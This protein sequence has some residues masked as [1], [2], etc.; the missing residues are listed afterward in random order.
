MIRRFPVLAALAIILAAGACAN[1]NAVPLG[2]AFGDAVESNTSRHVI[3]PEPA[4][5]DAGAPPLDG[6][7][8]AVVIERYR[9]GAVIVPEIIETTDFVDRAR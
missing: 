5:A 8:A 4:T 7:R 3:D 2:P 1:T 6:R 9:T